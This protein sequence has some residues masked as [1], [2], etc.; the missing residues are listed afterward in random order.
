[1]LTPTVKLVFDLPAVLEAAEDSVTAAR[2]VTR[3]I[4]PHPMQPGMDVDAGPCLQLVR[5][6]GVYLLSTNASP[7][8]KPPV[9]ADGFDP[10]D[11]SWSRR[12]TETGLPGGDFTEYLELHD[13]GLLAEIRAQLAAGADLMV[14]ALSEHSYRITYAQR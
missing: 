7:D 10:A 11:E 9:Y 13:S 14:I 8:R 4:Q 2:R 6:N 3:W 5:D 1:M 12:W